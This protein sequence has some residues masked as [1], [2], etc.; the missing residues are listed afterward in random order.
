VIEHELGLSPNT[1]GWR[2]AHRLVDDYV[3]WGLVRAVE[4]PGTRTVEAADEDGLFR[5]IQIG[6]EQY[7]ADHLLGQAL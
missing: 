5:V 2:T 1:P 4:R 6:W 3:A 7:R